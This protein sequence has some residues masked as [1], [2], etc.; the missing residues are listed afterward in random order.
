LSLLFLISPDKFFESGNGDHSK[1]KI[2]L[3]SLNSSRFNDVC[4]ERL[5]LKKCCNFFC[6]KPIDEVLFSKAK[7]QKFILSKDG[8]KKVEED[9]IRIAFCDSTLVSKG[10]S[11]CRENYTK[12]KHQVDNLNEGGPFGTPMQKLAELLRSLKDHSELLDIDKVKIEKVLTEFDQEISK[13]TVPIFDRVDKREVQAKDGNPSDGNYKQAQE[14]EPVEHKP[15]TV[16]MKVVSNRKPL[17]TIPEETK[18]ELPQEP[19]AKA[20]ADDFYVTEKTLDYLDDIFE[21]S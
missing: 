13:V 1:L 14:E 17:P 21:E 5:S 7:T 18:V 6:Q 2:L 10:D 16:K 20:I 15:K 8:C 19:E 11:P 3:G 4:E 9:G 12:I